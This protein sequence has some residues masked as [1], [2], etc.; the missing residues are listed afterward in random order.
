MTKLMLLLSFAMFFSACQNE[1]NA[2]PVLGNFPQAS[3]SD[4]S[5]SISPK[6][7]A[8]IEMTHRKRLHEFSEPERIDFIEETISY[9][10]TRELIEIVKEDCYENKEIENNPN[11]LEIRAQCAHLI[12]SNIDSSLSEFNQKLPEIKLCLNEQFIRSNLWVENIVSCFNFIIDYIT[13]MHKE[14]DCPASSKR[15]KQ[16]YNEVVERH[17]GEKA[18][19]DLLMEDV[20]NLFYPCLH[21]YIFR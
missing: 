12:E 21:K 20:D 11:C 16:I 6:E 7:Q 3:V 8:V 17:G 5:P 4:V 9:L 18:I 1:K 14:L 13:T 15:T 10:N 2:E 19:E